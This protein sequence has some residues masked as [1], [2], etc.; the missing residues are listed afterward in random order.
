MR[1]KRYCER[2][3]RGAQVRRPFF[4]SFIIINLALHPGSKSREKVGSRLAERGR[5]EAA[6]PPTG[7]AKGRR[8]FL[9]LHRLRKTHFTCYVRRSSSW[10]SYSFNGTSLA[11]QKDAGYHVGLLLSGYWI[12]GQIADGLDVLT[13]EIS[14]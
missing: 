1:R 4:H 3:R 13:G 6:P 8:T 14:V 2:E 10:N 5:G 9:S 11:G 12:Y 7:S